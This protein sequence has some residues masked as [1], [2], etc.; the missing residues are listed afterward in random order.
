MI[1]DFPDCICE[2]LSLGCFG[3]AVPTALPCTRVSCRR[4]AELRVREQQLSGHEQELED[5]W[6]RLRDQ[7]VP[8]V[9]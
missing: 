9:V 8:A 5:R 7:V 4:D 6:R 1:T 3:M 2:Y